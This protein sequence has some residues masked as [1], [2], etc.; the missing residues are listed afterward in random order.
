MDNECDDT[1]KMN[2]DEWNEMNG[3]KAECQEAYEKNQKVD[4]RDK[5]LHNK[6][7]ISV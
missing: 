6:K 7:V 1:Q 3:E 2:W 5:V 4:T